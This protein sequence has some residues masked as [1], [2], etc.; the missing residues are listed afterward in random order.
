VRGLINKVTDN[1]PRDI[2]QLYCSIVLL[3]SFVSPKESN[4]EKAPLNESLRALRASYTLVSG[5][6]I[7]RH[8]LAFALLLFCFFKRVGFRIFIFLSIVLLCKKG[9][10]MGSAEE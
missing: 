7:W 10:T 6:S 1:K 9:T 4:K 5:L 2:Y 8:A 3:L